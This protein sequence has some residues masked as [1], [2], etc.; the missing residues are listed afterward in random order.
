MFLL[1]VS[2][3]ATF[4]APLPYL[5]WRVAS[6]NRHGFF[7]DKILPNIDRLVFL[8][9]GAIM[10]VYLVPAN[11][12]S[13]GWASLGVTALFVFVP[14]LLTSQLPRLGR[15]TGEK[16]FMAVALSGIGAH[17]LLDGAAIFSFSDPAL[18]QLVTPMIILDRLTLGFLTFSLLYP[19]VGKWGGLAGIAAIAA[20]TVAGN[21]FVGLV[22]A[23]VGGPA[24]VAFINSVL[25]GLV[26][27]MT[28]K[29]AIFTKGLCAVHHYAHMKHVHAHGDHTHA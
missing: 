24:G 17:A 26:L 4:A 8:C 9:L 25:V 12:K 27:Y 29:H 1:I 3:I 23:A 20:L 28:V 22:L 7:Y 10:L 16:I 6:S 5:W 18:T 11:F 21:Q 2:I 19:R 14:W 15:E 13:I